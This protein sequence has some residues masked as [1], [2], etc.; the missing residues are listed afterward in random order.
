MNRPR[1]LAAMP[2]TGAPRWLRGRRRSFRQCHAWGALVGVLSQQRA[3]CAD[4]PW[5][6]FELRFCGAFSTSLQFLAVQPYRAL[7]RAASGPDEGR[8]KGPRSVAIGT[9]AA[10]VRANLTE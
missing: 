4:Q 8:I 2:P 5:R 10:I 6:R 1:R 3:I 9:A 7:R